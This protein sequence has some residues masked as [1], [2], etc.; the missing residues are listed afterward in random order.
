[1]QNELLDNVARYSN[2]CANQD[3]I[4]A[5]PIAGMNI[6][7]ATQPSL[8]NFAIYKPLVALVL[9]GA[10]SVSV[11]ACEQEFSAGESLIVTAEIPTISQVVRASPAKPYFSFITELDLPVLR[12]LSLETVEEDK[13]I[14]A[15]KI[16]QTDLDV[17]ATANRIMQ[18]VDRPDALKALGQSLK[19]E[20][21][22]WLIN[23]RHRQAIGL[24]TKPGSQ[25]TRIS[26]VMSYI[27]QHY[28]EPQ[29]ISDLAQRAGMSPTS[30]H[31]HFRAVTKLTPLQYQKQ[32]RLIEARRV[33][34][35]D[36]RSISTVAYD[37]GYES[38]PQF[39]REYARFFGSPPGR[40][41]RMSAA[42]KFAS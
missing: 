32:L 38:V 39:T 40:D 14:A 30:F 5:L 1:M 23:G 26:E 42:L 29:V 11:G 8:I 7:R 25:F 18:L 28:A 41:M 35:Q 36:G 21:H 31:Q 22:Y 33:M 10:K 4:A 6:V 13:N 27:R 2:A 34:L 19:R 16:E 15:V 3:G 12:E 37:V 17:A 24:I 9:Q 20:L